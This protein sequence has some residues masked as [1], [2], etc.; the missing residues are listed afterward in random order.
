MLLGIALLLA[1]LFFCYF[2]ASS[3]YIYMY[4]PF[5]FGYLIHT[6]GNSKDWKDTFK[7][8]SFDKAWGIDRRILW[9]N[10]FFSLIAMIGFLIAAINLWKL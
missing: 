8:K 4:R 7:N 5:H 2:L 3:L 10:S 6:K 1:I 9:W